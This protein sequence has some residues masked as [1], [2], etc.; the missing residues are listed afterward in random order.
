LGDAT[1]ERGMFLDLPTSTE[2]HAI[3]VRSTRDVPLS[4]MLISQ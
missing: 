1:H 3:H 2:V 4:E